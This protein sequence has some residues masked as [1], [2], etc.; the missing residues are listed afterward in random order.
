LNY[1]RIRLKGRCYHRI[2]HNGE[3]IVRL[4]VDL[5][6]YTHQKAPRRI[7]FDLHATGPRA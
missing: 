2:D 1:R 7:V 3:A 5:F 6:L 4:F